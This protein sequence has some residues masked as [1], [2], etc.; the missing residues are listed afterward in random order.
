MD[1]PTYF[2]SF[3]GLGSLPGGVVSGAALDE[4]AGRTIQRLAKRYDVSAQAMEHR[5]VNR[6]YRSAP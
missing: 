2:V 1:I 3:G 4:P 5:L 6:G